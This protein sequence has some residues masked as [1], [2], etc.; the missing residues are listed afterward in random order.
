M[1]NTKKQMKRIGKE[2]VKGYRPEYWMRYEE[3]CEIP[4][5]IVRLRRLEHEGGNDLEGGIYSIQ[6]LRP[7]YVEEI[8]CADHGGGVY[9]MRFHDYDKKPLLFP[10]GWLETYIVRVAGT[11]NT[12]PRQSRKEKSSE[13]DYISQLV[14]LASLARPVLSR[15]PMVIENLYA[16]LGT[17]ETHELISRLASIYQEDGLDLEKMLC[18]I[19]SACDKA[20]LM[21]DNMIQN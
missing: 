5:L 14:E 3:L 13:A 16:S 18:T 7:L 15:L 21:A 11:P 2:I 17:D 12:K 20:G 4:D 6:Q 10:D 9:E 19:L 8:I 1:E